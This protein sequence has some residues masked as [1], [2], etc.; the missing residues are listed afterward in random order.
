MASLN[1]HSSLPPLP[2]AARLLGDN[3]FKVTRETPDS[4]QRI[5][6]AE[7]VYRYEVQKKDGGKVTNEVKYRPIKVECITSESIKD[8]SNEDF[9]KDF[10]KEVHTAVKLDRLLKHEDHI[11]YGKDVEGGVTERFK[12][13]DEGGRKVVRV[14]EETGI[15][16][17]LSVTVSKMRASLSTLFKSA[18]A[19]F[20][21]DRFAFKLSNKYISPEEYAKITTKPPPRE[22]IELTD[23][24]GISTNSS[25]SSTNSSIVYSDLDTEPAGFENYSSS[26]ESVFSENDEFEDELA[27][28]SSYDPDKMQTNL[29]DLDK[30]VK[31]EDT[32]KADDILK[33]LN[34]DVSFN[35]EKYTL[36][37][38]SK[39]RENLNKLYLV[40]DGKE[41]RPLTEMRL[42]M[43]LLRNI[44]EVNMK[45][46]EL[47]V[48]IEEI[49]L[50]DDPNQALQIQKE[51]KSLA[52]IIKNEGVKG[53]RYRSMNDCEDLLKLADNCSTLLKE[54]GLLTKEM[55]VTIDFIKDVVNEDLEKI[56]KDKENDF[57]VMQWK[58]V[59]LEGKAKNEI[60]DNL[61]EAQTFLLEFYS[62]V[63]SRDKDF[64][65]AQGIVT[66]LK[67]HLSQMENAPTAAPAPTVAPARPTSQR[68]LLPGQTPFQHL[69]KQHTNFKGIFTPVTSAERIKTASVLY[70]DATEFV[71][72]PELNFE[73][74]PTIDVN[75]PA[76]R[77]KDEL[78]FWITESQ[79]K[80]EGATPQDKPK[81][82][83]A[84][85]NLTKS[86]KMLFPG[87]E[88]PKADVAPVTAVQQAADEKVTPQTLIRDVGNFYQLLNNTQ[89]NGL[90][91]AFASDLHKHN[92][93]VEQILENAEAVK[94]EMNEQEIAE[95]NEIQNSIYLLW[96][97][98]SRDVF[99]KIFEESTPNVNKGTQLKELGKMIMKFSNPE[100][101]T[102]APPSASSS[103]SSSSSSS[104]SAP[105]SR[106]SITLNLVQKEFDDL[107]R[108]IVAIRKEIGKLTS[109]QTQPDRAVSKINYD[110]LFIELSR[111]VQSIKAHR[112]LMTQPETNKDLENREYIE[113]TKDQ[114]KKLNNKI[115]QA[116]RDADKI[117]RGE[118]G[119]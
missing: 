28:L 94:T 58:N 29:K 55:Q 17:K 68:S 116:L 73:F 95:F 11:R 25:S 31:N 3:R 76:K 66:H 118:L 15:V 67:D 38:R 64:S 32:S 90:H 70:L 4:G 20:T 84:I 91:E 34:K 39:L 103:T 48:L 59:S 99:A 2:S 57:R 43:N 1:P 72:K 47:S 37:E 42:N 23:F 113:K 21:N 102:A 117:L 78:T 106:G 79:K 18:I 49:E 54:Y 45:A 86:A 60:Q 107:D 119:V 83:A 71:K 51:V 9:Q 6:K 88:L 98:V 110:K 35:K 5:L 89:T 97:S 111:Q 8:Y 33:N 27:L 96:Q 77:I 16:A 100:A 40:L 46:E 81:Y 93:M 53:N 74:P 26:K 22:E 62:D 10:K 80:A 61:N 41:P 63:K 92:K 50:E 82:E 104:S 69:D 19:T 7:I 105:T 114:F 24:S 87:F 12:Y 75:Q 112:H 36:E 108:T 115:T 85:S 65:F 101:S 52:E 109:Y 44:D 30:M 13:I 56:K 14:I